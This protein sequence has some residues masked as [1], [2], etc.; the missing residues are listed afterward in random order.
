LNPKPNPSPR[1]P[2][3]ACAA[4]RHA[5][6]LVTQLYEEELRAHLAMPQFA[7][8]SVIRHRPGCSQ[9]VLARALDFDKT[10]LSRN[11]KL[12]EKNGWITH[13]LSSD[14]RVRGYRI[15]PAGV[16]LLLAAKP[17]WD[18]AQSRFRSAMSKGQWDA[19]WKAFGSITEAARRARIAYRTGDPA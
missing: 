14:Q 19:M 5:A 17:G 10:T 2:G 18:R 3:C 16:G 11:L 1:E 13:A 9:A 15:T 4:V 8:L 7:L 6:R 12:M